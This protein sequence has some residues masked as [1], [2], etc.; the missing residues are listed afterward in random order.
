MEIF[1]SSVVPRMV[2]RMLK[3]EQSP[4]QAA[5]TGAAEMQRIADKWKQVA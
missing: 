4:E 3:G 5:A 2:A 1:N